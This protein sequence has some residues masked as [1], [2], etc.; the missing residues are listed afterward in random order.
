MK[1]ITKAG[2]HL[3]F[4]T[5][6]PAIILYFK[7]ALHD[8]SSLPGITVSS[9]QSYSEIIVTNF[10]LIVISLLGSVPVF[11][12]SF[13]CL[14]PKLIFKT[15]VMKIVLYAFGLT[16]YFLIVRL[17]AEQIFPLYFFFGTPFS[18]KVLA[19]IILLSALSGSL[20][21]FS[22]RINHSI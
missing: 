18:F 16:V 8:I 2:L 15:N 6:V 10:D 19:P 4:W 13:Y 3:L 17:I 12:W 7:W 21:A 9:S 1:T 22:K 14:T 11:Y 20:F 5:A